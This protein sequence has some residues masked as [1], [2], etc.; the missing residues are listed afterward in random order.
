M[1]LSRCLGLTIAEFF[2]MRKLDD[3]YMWWCK[4]GRRPQPVQFVT[5]LFLCMNVKELME[6]EDIDVSGLGYICFNL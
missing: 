5:C 1:P 4:E 2:A 6:H 3:E